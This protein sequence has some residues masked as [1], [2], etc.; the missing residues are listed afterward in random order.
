MQPYK[1]GTKLVVI[2]Y[3]KFTR[4]T[5]LGHVVMSA[6]HYKPGMIKYTYYYCDDVEAIYTIFADTLEA[7]VPVVEC[8][9]IL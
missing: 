4:M 3:S 2:S 1:S 9:R 5:I 6:W 8:T 7:R